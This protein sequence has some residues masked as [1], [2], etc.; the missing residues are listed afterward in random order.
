VITA[1]AAC[2]LA[3]V[4]ILA[5]AASASHPVVHVTNRHKQR[6]RRF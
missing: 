6:R 5:L 4:A 3:A 2:L 1:I